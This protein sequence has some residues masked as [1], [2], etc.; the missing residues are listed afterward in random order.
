M[1]GREGNPSLI[2][3]VEGDLSVSSA[4]SVIVVVFDLE[5]VAINL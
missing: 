3:E 4:Y 5:V 1:V 2:S